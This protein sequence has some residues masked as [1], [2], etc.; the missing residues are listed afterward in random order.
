MKWTHIGNASLWIGAMTMLFGSAIVVQAA[1]SSTPSRVNGIDRSKQS[2]RLLREIKADA[3]AVRSGAT[4]LDNLAESASAKWSDFDRQWN[5]M[6]PSVEDMQ[7]KLARLET[8]QSALTPAERTEVDRTK[9]LVQAI[10]SRTNRFLTLLD[11]PGVPT[12]DAKFKAY[13][14]SLRNEANQIEKLVP[15]A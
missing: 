7:I 14:R 4:H 1:S 11:T 2:A 13:A 6:A 3:E 9:P 10:Q 5:E 8:M 15:V 12:T